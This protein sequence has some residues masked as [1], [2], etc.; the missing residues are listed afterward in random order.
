[1]AAF[2]KDFAPVAGHPT[3]PIAPRD[4]A[5]PVGCLD[6]SPF[7]H[8]ALNKPWVWSNPKGNDLANL[9]QGIVQLGGVTFDIRGV[10]QLWGRGVYAPFPVRIE[11]IPVAQ[12]GHRIHFLM[13]TIHE[14]KSGT[15]VGRYQIHYA[16]GP[17]I[18]VPIVYGQDIWEW[19]FDLKNRP[20]IVAK[21]VW[22]GSS[23]FSQTFHKR[24][25]LFD[26]PWENTQPD[27]AIDSI[28]FVSAMTLSAPFLI[29]I[30]VE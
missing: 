8:S 23:A 28:D 7:Y 4:P 29:A 12:Q 19:W 24:V 1:V 20:N 2:A 9:P 21:P 18:Q 17:P 6:L 10:I 25:W 30:T 3:S 27:I 13:G 26:V 11:R 14:E 22:E 5:T 16:H 15:Q